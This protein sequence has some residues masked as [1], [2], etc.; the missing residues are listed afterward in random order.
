M[1]ISFFISAQ[2]KIFKK[3]ERKLNK[4]EQMYDFQGKKREYFC[5]V[6][7]K[8]MQKSRKSNPYN[9]DTKSRLTINCM[10]SNHKDL[11]YLGLSNGQFIAVE[12]TV[13][14]PSKQQYLF[15]TAHSINCMVIHKDIA[16]IGT[17]S[18]SVIEYNFKT[19]TETKV[20]SDDQSLLNFVNIF[21]LF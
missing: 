5:T 7:S 18:G 13:N 12:M 4:I 3:Q 15:Q 10:A 1:F 2:K 16:F 19:E 21:I 6:S 11:L 20:V 8:D 9:D 14:G 17:D